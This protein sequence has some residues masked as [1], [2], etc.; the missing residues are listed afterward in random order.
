LSRA[1]ASA[2]LALLTLSTK[3]CVV[4]SV[5]DVVVRQLR[6]LIFCAPL[7]A[8]PTPKDS[9]NA[10]KRIARRTSRDHECGSRKW[11]RKQR[12]ERQSKAPK[13]L[14]ERRNSVE[15]RSLDTSM[16]DSKSRQAIG[17]G[18]SRKRACGAAHRVIRP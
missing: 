3:R 18:R 1:P 4:P 5:P 8:R 16:E 17:E 10:M 2:F 14:H 9:T 12:G 15:H 11:W 7:H 13:T 6:I